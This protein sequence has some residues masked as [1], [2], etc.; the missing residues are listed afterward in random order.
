MTHVPRD[1][2]HQ[3]SES[4]HPTQHVNSTSADSFFTFFFLSHSFSCALSPNS[5]VSPLA[6]AF[7]A[8]KAANLLLQWDAD[9]DFCC[10][11]GLAPIHAAASGGHRDILELLINAGAD[12]LKQSSSCGVTARHI[13]QRRGDEDMARLLE[14]KARGRLYG[15]G[16][17]SSGGQR[18]MQH[19]SSTFISKVRSDA[20]SE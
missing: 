19:H 4:I 17:D 20:L 16:E 9:K 13:A 15:S 7:G 6:A 11:R 10:E 5:R 3:W 2:H 18:K 1:R 12:T 8:T 14:I